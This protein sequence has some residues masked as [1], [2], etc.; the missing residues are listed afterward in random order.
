MNLET[1]I[2]QVLEESGY[3][4][5]PYFTHLKDGQ[6]E[7]DDFVATQ[8]QFFFAVV[9]FSRPMA[10][11][12]AKIP[13]PTARLEVL[14]NVWEEHGEGNLSSGH[15][16]TFLEFLK[17]IA[18]LSPPEVDQ[19]VLWPEVRIF[20]TTLAG[21]ALLDHYVVGV[22]L[23][24][25]IERMFS[26][27]SGWIGQG[28]VKRGWLTTDTLVHYKVH[29]QL[30]IKHSDD[31]FAILHA[32]FRESAVHRYHVE[33]GLRL[34]ATLFNGLYEGLWRARSRRWV[35]AAPLPVSATE[36]YLP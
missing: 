19:R 8:V 6:F 27:I 5:N 11:L 21:A 22:A 18:G 33:Q 20:N 2:Q 10:A 36:D 3:R 30:D 14:R 12:A 26:E 15:G 25:I 7:K 13:S 4:T 1:L 31:F 9:F 32:P 24:G 16:T 34:G 28:V 35:L 23:L 17:R 29:E